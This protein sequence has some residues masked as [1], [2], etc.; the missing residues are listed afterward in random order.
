MSAALAALPFLVLYAICA[1]GLQ[2]LRRIRE[3][4]FIER[5][6]GAT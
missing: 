6:A 4:V 3:K 1:G 5:I 2:G